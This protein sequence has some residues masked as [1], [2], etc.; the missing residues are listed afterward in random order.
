MHNNV[1][2]SVETFLIGYVDQGNMTQRSTVTTDSD[3]H[4]EFMSEGQ[5]LS[6]PGWELE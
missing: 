2:N 5:G 1:F 3:W 4:S 6:P